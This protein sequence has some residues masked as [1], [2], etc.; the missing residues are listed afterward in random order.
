MI[1]STVKSKL[2]FVFCVLVSFVLV[3]FV[4]ASTLAQN[5]AS[6]IGISASLRT[7]QTDILIPIWSQKFV[8]APAI[9]VISVS[10]A[11]TD[12]GLG[13][14]IRR[15]LSDKMA[16]PYISLRSG[17]LIFDPEGNSKNIVDYVVGPAVGGEYFLD[18]HFSVAV[19]AQ[20]NFSFSD[21]NSLRFGNRNGGTNVNTAT[22]I[23]ATFYF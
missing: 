20:L 18:D 23:I 1:K 6:K 10:D 5:D 22:S 15:N 2:L 21:E 11:L 8:I 14:I 17:I 12:W 3:Q 16:V 9:S 19:E 4:P 13:L 7:D